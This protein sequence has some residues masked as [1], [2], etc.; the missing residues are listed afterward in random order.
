MF[1]LWGK[2]ASIPVQG[3]HMMYGLGTIIG[4]L[5]MEPFLGSDA[6]F[7]V[8]LNAT[9]TNISQCSDDSQ[10]EIGFSIAAAIISLFAG[11]ALVF[12]F[13]GAPE[14]IKMHTKSDT[15]NSAS[16]KPLSVDISFTVVICILYGLYCIACGGREVVH[17]NWL[18]SY[19]TVSDLSMS[20]QEATYLVTANQISFLIGRLVSIF[21]SYIVPVQLVFFLNAFVGLGFTV[22]LTVLGTQDKMLFWIFSCLASFACSPLIP[23]GLAW[24]DRYTEVTAVVLMVMSFGFTVGGFVSQWLA[25]WML[26]NT[27]PDFVLYIELGCVIAMC[28]AITIM[29]VVG[30]KHGNRYVKVDRSSEV[31]PLISRDSE[32]M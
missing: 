24:L 12:F 15:Y 10:I 30:S 13:I 19:A 22:C 27:S 2:G 16:S 28:I 1:A 7:D 11:I 14:N 23:V 8:N 25:G 31:S 17:M 5:V 20:N 4:P 18:F 32:R 9:K 3:I 21:A 6:K 26:T 29:Q